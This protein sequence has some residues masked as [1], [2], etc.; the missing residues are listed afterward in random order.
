M[1]LLAALFRPF[2]KVL[3]KLGICTT[4][5]FIAGAITGFLLFCYW[6][7]DPATPVVTTGEF[8]KIA[9]MLWLF[10]FLTI[11][12]ILVVFC[13]YTIASVF[14]QTLLN[15]LL[16]SVLTTF[17]VI[18]LDLMKWAFWVGIFIGL[19]IGRLLCLICQKLKRN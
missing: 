14:F 17:V 18:K 8:W 9:G 3:N 13:R 15:T 12:F 1:K 2:E 4:V 10:S 5:G 16:S 7:N 6:M 19:V 11:L